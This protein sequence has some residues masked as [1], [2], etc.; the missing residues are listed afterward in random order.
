MKVSRIVSTAALIALIGAGPGAALSQTISVEPEAAIQ[1]QGAP[2]LPDVRDR[3]AEI[4]V[5][6]RRRN[7]PRSPGLSHSENTSKHNMRSREANTEKR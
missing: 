6:C 4:G 2:T 3:L 1:A 7:S 5:A